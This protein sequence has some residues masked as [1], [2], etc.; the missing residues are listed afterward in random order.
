MSSVNPGITTADASARMDRLP[1]TRSHILWVVLLGVAMLIETFD[2][3]VFTYLAPSIRADWGMSLGQVGVISSAVFV[4]MLIGA[5]VGGRLSDRFG[6]RPVLIWSSVAYAAMSLLS[7]VAPN[8]EILA[9]SRVLTGLGVQAAT[10]VV[11]VYAGEMFPRLF[12]GRAYT[13][14]TF[15]GFA[16]APVTALTALAIAPTGVSAWRWVFV[17]GGVGLL[18]A[19]AAALW[20]PETV[21]WLQM[22]GRTDE[23]ARI[24][25]RLEQSAVRRGHTLPD[26]QPTAPMA[27]QGSFRE[28]FH[29]DNLKRL[30][31]TSLAF[32]AYVYANYGF[33][34]WVPT[35]LTDRGMSQPDA[36]RFA[37]VLTFSVVL[38][39]LAM[40]PFTDRIE[41]KT[42]IMLGSV[43]ACAGLV[44]F[45]FADGTGTSIVAG[46][47]AMFGFS[48]MGVAF[49]TYVPE[50]FPTNIR[51]AGFGVVSGFARIAGIAAGL[52][53]AAIYQGLGFEV[54]Y[55]MLAAIIL[56]GGLIVLIF[57]PKTTN[58]SL[59]A[60]SS[61]VVAH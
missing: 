46:F 54:L 8:F 61:E 9:V 57:G 48:V 13:V 43:L 21:R 53:V 51:G 12:R 7:A 36:L 40:F 25:N 41:R 2:N 34:S 52:T 30:I 44:A 10:G 47:V 17:L 56:G 31:I 59:E 37:L 24:V 49:Y 26:V 15:I 39:P 28:L 42:T 1:P 50:V 3:G 38:A 11:L 6:R 27:T 5:V 20:L 58:R 14:L 22:R 55:S 60:I 16:G 18:V 23:A 4:G 29:R 32:F 19:V 45:A 33:L 35:I